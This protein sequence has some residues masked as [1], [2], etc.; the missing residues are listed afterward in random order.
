M[1]VSLRPKFNTSD[2]RKALQERQDRIEA[3]ML[4]RVRRAGEQFVASARENGNYRDR[5][6][7]LRSSIGYVVLHDGVQ[8]HIEFKRAGVKAKKATVNGPEQS[9]KVIG[10][11]KGNYPKGFV[12]IGVAGMEY[13]AAVESR[14][15]DVITFTS[16]EVAVDLKKGLEKLQAKAFKL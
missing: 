5:T 4:M 10:E 11:L 9:A 13:A 1:A 12:L 3:A 15:Y 7:N 8:V 14:G 16:I 2:I 6:S